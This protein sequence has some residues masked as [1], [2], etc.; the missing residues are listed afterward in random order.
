[1]PGGAE[2]IGAITMAM[3]TMKKTTMKKY[4]SLIIILCFI[5]FDLRF[6]LLPHV[7]FLLMCDI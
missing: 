3:P 1:M 4:N 2:N 7:W 6:I 5:S